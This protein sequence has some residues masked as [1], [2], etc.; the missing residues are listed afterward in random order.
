LEVQDGTEQTGF[1]WVYRKRSV[2]QKEI[3]DSNR[4]R[5]LAEDQRLF[6]FFFF[7]AQGRLFSKEIRY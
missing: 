4:M 6:L 2:G 7:H 1:Y 3:V 5:K